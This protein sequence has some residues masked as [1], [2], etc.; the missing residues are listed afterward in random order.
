MTLNYLHS[1]CND[2]LASQ[3]KGMCMHILSMYSIYSVYTALGA[4]SYSLSSAKT[5]QVNGMNPTPDN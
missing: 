5:M 3:L 2:I 1:V 4:L